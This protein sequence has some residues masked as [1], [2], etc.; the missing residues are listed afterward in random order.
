MPN[1]R[2]RGNGHKLKHRN[3]LFQHNSFF[4]ARVTEHRNRL[5]RE[6]VESRSLEKFKT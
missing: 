4:T 2:A 1:D 6:V 5:L 3:L